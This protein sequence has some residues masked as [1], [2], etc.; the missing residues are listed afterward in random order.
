MPIDL[1]NFNPGNVDELVDA[2]TGE[3]SELGKKWWSTNSAIV[4]GYIKSLAEAT[5]QTQI[6]LQTRDIK[7][8]QADRIMHMQE[9]AFTSTLHFTKYMT[10]VLA[11]RVLDTTFTIVGWAFFNRT[12]V[13]IFP[14][15]VKPS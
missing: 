5:L 6:A 11:Q 4:E 7:P 2:I 12:G 1:P 13:N 10:F 9:L 15:L 8:D 3:I 14:Q